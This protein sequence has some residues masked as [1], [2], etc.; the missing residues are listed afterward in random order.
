[1]SYT[2]SFTT[3]DPVV[4]EYFPDPLDVSEGIWEMGLVS[5]HSFHTVPNV[6][7]KNNSLWYKGPDMTG[8]TRIRIP[9]GAYPIDDL[10]QAI[11]KRLPDK[12]EFELGIDENTH[13]CVILSNASIDFSQEGT[14]RELLGFGAEV[15][16]PD[17]PHNSSHPVNIARV[18]VLRVLCSI[19]SGSYDNGAHA[20]IIHEFFPKVPP[21]YKIVEVPKNI[22]YLPINVSERIDSITLTLTDQYGD[23]LD[24]RGEIVNIRLHLRRTSWV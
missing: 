7:D 5:F 15:L 20:H 21:G 22:I 1:M 16:I 17:H 18:N 11:Y 8:Y 3:T 14:L 23:H 9:P 13:K 2:F 10:A 24:F 6:T 19:T 4:T 12:I